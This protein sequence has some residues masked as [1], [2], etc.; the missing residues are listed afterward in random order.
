MDAFIGHGH[1]PLLEL[2]VEVWQ[3]LEGP[4]APEEVFLHVAHLPLVLAL[5]LG[6]MGPAGL[7]HEAVVPGQLQE[8]RAE[9]N[10][11]P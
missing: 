1:Q 10:Q 8:A 6:P 11:E 3:A 5:G 2:L 4:V 7:R 9:S